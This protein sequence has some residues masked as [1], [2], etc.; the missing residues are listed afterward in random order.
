MNGDPARCVCVEVKAVESCGELSK[1][2]CS[3]TDKG[4]VWAYYSFTVY[5]SGIFNFGIFGVEICWF[6]DIFIP[7]Y[8]ILELFNHEKFN[9][10][11]FNHAIFD[12]GIF[13]CGIM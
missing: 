7:T 6:W 11:A 9:F 1:K 3:V 10:E 4:E 5:N 13:S 12:S 2:C 8:L